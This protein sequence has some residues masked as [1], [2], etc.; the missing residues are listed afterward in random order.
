M[1]G[2]AGEEPLWSA[3]KERGGEKTHGKVGLL[4]SSFPAERAPAGYSAIE[5][6]VFSLLMAAKYSGICSATSS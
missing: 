2:S 6:K 5:V 1:P 4:S 3:S